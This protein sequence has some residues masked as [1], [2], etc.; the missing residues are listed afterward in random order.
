MHVMLLRFLLHVLRFR[1]HGMLVINGQK[2]MIMFNSFFYVMKTVELLK[3]IYGW[4]V[5][6]KKAQRHMSFVVCLPVNV[7]IGRILQSN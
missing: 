4:T 2:T 6:K 7:R 3:I 5:W 1:N